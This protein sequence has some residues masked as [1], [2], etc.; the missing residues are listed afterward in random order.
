M[1]L[2]SEAKK[3]KIVI[4]GPAVQGNRNKLITIQI[5]NAQIGEVIFFTSSCI[6]GLQEKGTSI[7]NHFQYAK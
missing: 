2:L 6:F 7:T 4:Y 5:K 1:V 3:P